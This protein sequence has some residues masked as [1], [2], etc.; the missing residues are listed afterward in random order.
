[1]PNGTLVEF[2]VKDNTITFTLPENISDGAVVMIPASG[3]KVAIATIGV[4][5]GFVLMMILDVALG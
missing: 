5:I 1:M 3:V 2:V 4:A